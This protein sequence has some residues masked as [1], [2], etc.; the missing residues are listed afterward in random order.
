MSIRFK[1]KGDFKKIKKF[2]VKHSKEVFRAML[3]D[4]GKRGVE[5]L[6]SATPVD[7]GVTRDSWYYQIRETEKSTY[8]SWHNSNATVSGTPIVILLR[9]GHATN[10]GGYVEG[11][12]FIAPSI[13]PIFDGFTKTMWEEVQSS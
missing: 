8:L 7:S 3:E 5:A 9:Y 13:R 11:Y 1:T 6:A 4:Y 12:D 10:N 2:L